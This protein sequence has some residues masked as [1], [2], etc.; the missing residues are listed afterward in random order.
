MDDSP[1]LT[2]AA[3]DEGQLARLICRAKG[4][5]NISFTWARE[6]VP[7]TPDDKYSLNTVQV[8]IVTWE[9]TLFV[10]KVRSRDYGPYDCVARNEMGTGNSRV[11]L[12]GT[13]RPDAPF[14]LTAVNAT[15]DSVELAW[16]PGF[17]GGIS[18]AYRIRYRQVICGLLHSN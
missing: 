2:K 8:D 12:S 11:I 7:L 13:S 14:W 16:K 9:S 4:A 5:P 18:Q 3:G 6:G 15:H 17:D 10:S 1:Q